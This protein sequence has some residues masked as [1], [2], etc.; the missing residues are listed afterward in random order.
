MNNRDRYAKVKEYILSGTNIRSA[1]SKAGLS[2]SAY[3]YYRKS[4]RKTLSDSEHEIS[5]KLLLLYMMLIVESILL[6]AFWFKIL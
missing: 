4:D 1:C 6:I 5:L 3:Y 2:Q